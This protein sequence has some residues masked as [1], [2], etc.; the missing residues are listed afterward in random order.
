MASTYSDLKFE[1]IGTGD[2][3]GV[4]GTTTNDNIGTAIEQA[5]VGLGNPVFT[6]DANLTISLTNTVALQTAR[7]L[8]LNATSSG[9][10]T[11]TRE[12][13]VP[14]I[15][16]QYIV[17]N[18]TTGGQSI[19][20][21]T[22][23]GT[24][25][26]VTNGRK[27]HL[28]VDG[29][30]VIQMFDFVDINGGAIDGTPIGAA[31]ASTGAFSTLTTSS[32]VTI[33]GGTANGV[34][35]LNGSKVLTTGS[36]LTFDGTALAPDGT[37][38]TLGTS[39][40]RWGTVFATS[41]ADGTDQLVGSSGATARFGF[42]ASW[43]SQ[44]FAISGTEQMR[45]NSTGLGIGTSSPGAKLDVKGGAV[46]WGV[47]TTSRDFE[48]TSDASFVQLQSY[49]SKPLKLNAQGNNVIVESNLGLGVTPSA[50]GTG[51]KAMQIAGYVAFAQRPAGTGDLILSWNAF[52]TS[53]N[54]S[55]SGY[56]YKNTGDAASSYEQNGAH[57]WYIA[58]S[59]TAGN[60][61]TFT[62][63]MTLDTSGNL[64]IGTSSPTQKLHVIGN[65]QV[66]DSG[67]TRGVY[68][69]QA[70]FSGA[71]LYKSDGNCE[72]SPRSGFSLIFAASPEGTERARID[73]SGNFFVG[74]TAGSFGSRITSYSASSYT[75]ESIRTGTGSEGHVAFVNANGAVGSIF[76]N[77]T[78]T[79]Y[80]TT[81]DYR[82]K[83]VIGPVADAGQ[84]IDA[85]QPVEY[86]WNTDGSR[87]RGF[88]A[89]KFQEVYPSSVTGSKDAVDAE[90]KPVYQ[91]MQASTSEVIA[92]LVAEIQS[93]RARVLALESN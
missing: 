46:F 58:P 21:K 81:S 78:T 39:S 38:R 87:T 59:G 71:F 2:Q 20:V 48:I 76:T 92:D 43:T 77:G 5:L 18:N 65:A 52:N 27:A 19:T 90:G 8:V 37:G 93:L 9:S 17:Q 32:T 56:V 7:A 67:N 72:L 16:K 15:E 29:T 14:T 85:L 35:Y 54:T 55:G 13:V 49:N 44:T 68:V 74:A 82:L 89:H 40:L 63:A 84:R 80:N 3:S 23:A 50:W 42:G 1:L 91:Q 66:G 33:N 10:L 70:G 31:S 60:A 47:S 11:A 4:W 25:I 30:N 6:T 34:A 53:G 61:I 36:A 83:T 22:T 12:L 45:L 57:R 75:F 64:G 69:G 41:F 26:T 51:Y 73:T 88:L 24:G 79:S 28:Y 86:T 62:Q